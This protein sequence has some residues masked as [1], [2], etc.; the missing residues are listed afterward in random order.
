MH[1]KQ[2]FV[3]NIWYKYFNFWYSILFNYLPKFLQIDVNLLI[4]QV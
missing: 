2:I 1:E 4:L 3:W